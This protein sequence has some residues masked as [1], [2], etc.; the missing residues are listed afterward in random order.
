VSYE[1]PEPQR[2]AIERVTSS[3]FDVTWERM[4]RD[5][6]AASFRILSHDRDSRFLVVEL[7]HSSGPSRYV[8]CGRVSRSITLD[9]R[10]EEYEYGL[11][12]PGRHR[13]VEELEDGYQISDVTRTLQLVARATLYLRPD[14]EQRARVTTQIRY[15][16]EVEISG[17]VTPL[18]RQAGL[19]EGEVRPLA[20]RRHRV[21]FATFETGALPSDGE[22]ICRATGALEQALL[23]VADPRGADLSAGTGHATWLSRSRKRASVRR[24]AG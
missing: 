19:P 12:E 20:P 5:L 3:P 21:H 8:D 2:I 23:A 14:G 16:L 4:L 1:A 11:A 22:A 10:T 15:E 24:E 6:P 17:T 7:Q 18:P 9:G 13:E